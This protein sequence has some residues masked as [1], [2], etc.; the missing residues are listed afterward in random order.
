MFDEAIEEPN[1]ISPS[2]FVLSACLFESS[3][4]QTVFTFNYV[5]IKIQPDA[6]VCRYLFTAKLLYMF[7][8]S[9]HLSSGVLKTVTAAS[10]TSI[11]T[12]TGGCGYSF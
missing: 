2:I 10:C 3:N 11:M 1:Y 7:R 9:R 8:V 4:H 5:L 6:T 12:C